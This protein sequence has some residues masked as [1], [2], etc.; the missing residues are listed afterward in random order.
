MRILDLSIA[1]RPDGQMNFLAE[2]RRGAL[3]CS[4]K[5]RLEP[6][7]SHGHIDSRPRASKRA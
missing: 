5:E 7:N 6:S 3:K 1:Q 4:L 2:F